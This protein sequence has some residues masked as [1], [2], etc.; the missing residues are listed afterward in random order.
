MLEPEFMEPRGRE[1]REGEKHKGAFLS[2]PGVFAAKSLFRP[3]TLEHQ[4]L[5]S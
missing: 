3:F 1:E 5:I 4:L 2:I